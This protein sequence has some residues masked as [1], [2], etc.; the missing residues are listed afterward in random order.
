M[1]RADMCFGVE[2]ERRFCRKGR[3]REDLG[4]PITNKI[5]DTL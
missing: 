2:G 5:L 4:E 1:H 3:G